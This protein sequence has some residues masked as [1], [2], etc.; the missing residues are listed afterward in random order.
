VPPE[1]VLPRPLTPSRAAASIETDFEAAGLARS[2]VLDAAEPAFAIARGLA[3]HKLLQLLPGLVPDGREAAALRYLERVGRLWLPGEREAA[4]APLMRIM[5]DPAFAPIFRIDSRAEVALS[6][7]LTIGGIARPI[8]GKVDR[9]AVSADSV[10]IVDYKTNRPHPERL[11]D[12]P[13]AYV[14]QL[15]LYRALLQPLY[16]DRGVRAA[17][18]F[19]EG[20]LLMPLPESVMDAALARLAGA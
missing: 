4:L 7:T 5:G 6:G 15:A 12:V 17:L 11:E 16:P 2:P 9:L 14:A 20:P 3:V 19:T 1:P 8:S 13:A 10:L 18:L